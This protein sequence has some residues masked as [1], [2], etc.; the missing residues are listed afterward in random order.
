[1]YQRGRFVSSGQ[2]A[3]SGEGVRQAFEVSELFR[4]ALLD[5]PVGLV[6]GLLVHAI[7]SGIAQA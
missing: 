5:V 3:E 4:L 1:V 7:V 6:V 2:Q